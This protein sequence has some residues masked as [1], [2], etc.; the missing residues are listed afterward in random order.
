MCIASEDTVGCCWWGE[1][2]VNTSEGGR[3]ARFGRKQQQQQLG[4]LISLFNNVLFADWVVWFETDL[5]FLKLSLIFSCFNIDLR[6]KSLFFYY[7]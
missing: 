7:G 3:K 2:G 4:V 1:G 5:L 6:F